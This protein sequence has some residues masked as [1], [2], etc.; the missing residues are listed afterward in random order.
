MGNFVVGKEFDALFVQSGQKEP[1]K[2]GVEGR[3]LEA[4]EEIMAWKETRDP[5]SA[6]GLNPAMFVEPEDS[7]EKV[8]E[9]VSL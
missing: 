6:E 2:E 1:E 9:K 7:L 4:D 8:F 5:F 3:G